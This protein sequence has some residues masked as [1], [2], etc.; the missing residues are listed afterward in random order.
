M[1]TAG[2]NQ[3]QY[4]FAFIERLVPPNHLRRDIAAFIDS[5]F[6]HDKVHKPRFSGFFL[7]LSLSPT[8][9]SFRQDA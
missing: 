2:H 6:Y 7:A 1:R 3:P 9:L 8:S 5:W 4:G